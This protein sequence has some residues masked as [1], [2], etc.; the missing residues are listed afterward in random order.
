MSVFGRRQGNQAAVCGQGFFKGIFIVLAKRKGESD[1]WDRH[2]ETAGP[3]VHHEAWRGPWVQELNILN[4][5]A[6]ARRRA[7][8]PHL[9][10][11]VSY[12]KG[13]LE[14]HEVYIRGPCLHGL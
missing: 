1:Q 14:S 9:Y 13:L 11:T 2:H 7:L 4:P 10:T 12:S 5:G 8:E 3:Q 6:L